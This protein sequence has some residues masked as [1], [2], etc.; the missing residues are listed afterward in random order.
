M[1][2]ILAI[3][4]IF[5]ITIVFADTIYLKNG[6]KVEG[7][8]ISIGADSVSVETSSGLLMIE[9][10]QIE[11]IE[12]A[13][14]MKPEERVVHEGAIPK[15]IKMVGFGCL[16]GIVGAAGAATAAVLSDGFGGSEDITTIVFGG[17]IILG[18]LAGVAIGG[19]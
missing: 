8:I 9:A 14:P 4:L 16:G 11:K 17:A 3:T 2:H 7:T 13:E 10:A 5:Y 19:K 12:T 1:K 15:S 6:L 18:V